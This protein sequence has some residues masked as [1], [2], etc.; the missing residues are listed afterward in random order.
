MLGKLLKHEMKALSRFLLPMHVI[1][2]VMSVIG[3]FAVTVRAD[4]YPRYFAPFLIISYMVFL[5]AVSFGTFLLVAMR[6]YKHLFSDEGYLTLTLPATVGQQLA[7]K[8][9]IAVIWFLIDLVV[10]I[11]SMMLLASIPGFL[12]ILPEINAKMSEQ[13]GFTVSSFATLFL[14]M[15]LVEIFSMP[16]YIYI[17]VTVGQLFSSHR[18]LSA[19][20]SYC[21][22][23]GMF[24]II[25]LMLLSTGGYLPYLFNLAELKGALY[26]DF[27]EYTITANNIVGTIVGILSYIGT[28]YI[29]KRRINLS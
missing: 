7:S 8:S 29:M 27:M 19:I 23:C 18:V 11:I 6:F 3:H 16:A 9:I 12:R 1:V 25:S 21:L 28:Y 20:I 4:S 5:I 17:C 24:Q 15:Y 14:I 22:L 26:R 10:I 13:T 2:L